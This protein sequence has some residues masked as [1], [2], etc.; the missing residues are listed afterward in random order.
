M[1]VFTSLSQL[2]DETQ[3]SA[4]NAWMIDE[5]RSSRGNVDDL[6]YCPFHP[7]A[8]LDTYRRV[9]DWRKPAAGMLLDLLGNWEVHAARSFMIGD[10]PSDLAA[11]AAANMPAYHFDGSD[12]LGVM[13]TLLRRHGG[14]GN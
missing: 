1:L 6:R 2:Y 14:E 4:L 12:L 11:A 13:R 5:I 8:V 3:F 10:Q 7:E 9:S